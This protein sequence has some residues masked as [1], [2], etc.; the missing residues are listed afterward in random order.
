MV[1]PERGGG[2]VPRITF[3]ESLV[4]HL[5]PV[6]SENAEVRLEIAENVVW[7]VANQAYL[8]WTRHLDYDSA[9]R[10]LQFGD[11]GRLDCE[12]GS[13]A[14]YFPDDDVIVLGTDWLRDVYANLWS[15]NDFLAQEAVEELFLVITHEAG[16]QF[17]Y[18][19]H[20]GSTDGC[21]GD[22]D[23]CHAPYGSA[24]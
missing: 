14:C 5:E 16:H 19:N 3:S 6:L 11:I 12:P 2:G 10:A 15:G 22:D 18:E 21:G 23:H 1:L 4:S 17:G 24:A 7:L 20:D 9:P 8:Q 13:I